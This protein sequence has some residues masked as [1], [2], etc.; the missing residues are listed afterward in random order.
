MWRNLALGVI[1]AV[2]AFLI[3][4]TAGTHAATTPNKAVIYTIK[5]Y[6]VMGHLL[7]TISGTQQEMDKIDQAER[8][9]RPTVRP[10]NIPPDCYSDCPPPGGSTLKNYLPLLLKGP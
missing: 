2:A 5:Y 9:G 3:L 6:D 1:I 4:P 7:K 8:K 10:S